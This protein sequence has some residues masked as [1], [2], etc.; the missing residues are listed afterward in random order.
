[1][2]MNSKV[3]KISLILASFIF[4]SGFLPFSAFVGPGIT[5]ASTGNV[6]KASAQYLIDNHVK[7]K[8]GKSSL[9]YVKDGVT[10]YNKQEDLNKDLKKLIETRVQETHKKLIKQTKENNSNKE[11]RQLVEKRIKLVSKKL[12]IKKINQ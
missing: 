9:A 5:V 10:K 3:F 1:M 8:T 11:F 6:Y 4:L 12:D 7:N 2:A